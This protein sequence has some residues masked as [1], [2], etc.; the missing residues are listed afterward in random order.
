MKQMKEWK[1]YKSLHK[2]LRKRVY[3]GGF[4]KIA[5]NKWINLASILISMAL[6][7]AWFD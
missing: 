3:K 4:Q 7:N 1:S 5:I 6:P 2:T